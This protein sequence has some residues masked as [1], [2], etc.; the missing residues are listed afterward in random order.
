[1]AERNLRVELYLDQDEASAEQREV[2]GKV[3]QRFP[4]LEVQEF[5]LDSSQALD[6]GIILAPGLVIDDVILGVGR[7]VSA[8]KIRRFL[9]SDKVEDENG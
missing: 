6:R 5:T 1:M 2:I 8:G 4:Q 7:V 3:S 9:E